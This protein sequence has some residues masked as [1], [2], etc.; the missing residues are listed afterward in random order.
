MAGIGK[1]IDGG[2]YRVD[3]V[4]AEAVDGELVVKLDPDSLWVN[5]RDWRYWWAMLRVAV[6]RLRGKR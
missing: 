2:W 5:R 1:Q 4:S 3:I 6:M